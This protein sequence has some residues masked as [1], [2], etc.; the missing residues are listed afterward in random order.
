MFYTLVTNTIHPLFIFKNKWA[1]KKQKLN[2][3]IRTKHVT[4]NPKCRHLLP[5]NAINSFTKPFHWSRQFLS[6]IVWWTLTRTLLIP[7]Q[8]YLSVKCHLYLLT[9]G[10]YYKNPEESNMSSLSALP[11]KHVNSPTPH[12]MYSHS[13]INVFKFKIYTWIM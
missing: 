10:K 5:L 9:C 13:F 8:S 7:P 4:Y 2:P 3:T 6:V 1:Q 12:N 11:I